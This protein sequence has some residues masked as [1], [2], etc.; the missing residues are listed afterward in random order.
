MA[1]EIDYPLIHVVRRDAQME[2][3]KSLGASHVLNSSAEDFPDRLRAT[4]E[5]LRATTA[6]DAVAGEMTGILVNT[7]P[8][9][10]RIYVY[11]ALSEDACNNIDPIELIFHGKSVRGF[12]LG[13]WLERR[14][15][16]GILRAAGRVQ[17]ML[18]DGRIQTGFQRRVGLREAPD[19]LRQYV[20]SMSDG[21]VL[22]VPRDAV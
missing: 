4:C 17:R 3:L 21:K 12:Y 16:L 15:V 18:I 9:K 13:A 19:G 14:G 22:I 20:G 7:M 1:A 8:L 10:S 6:F 11:G 5:R 2:L